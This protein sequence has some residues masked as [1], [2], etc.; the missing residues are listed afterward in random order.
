MMMQ[1]MTVVCHNGTGPARLWAEG[2][3]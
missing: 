1:Q 2:G 3:P